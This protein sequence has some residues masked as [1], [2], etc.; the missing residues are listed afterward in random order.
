MLTKIGDQNVYD[1][2][3]M[4]VSRQ[5]G[6]NDQIYLAFTDVDNEETHLF[7]VKLTKVND[8]IQLIQKAAANQKIE[9]ATEMPNVAGN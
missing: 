7:P 6:D 5:E 9:I 1:N 2:L 4:G 3:K 8:Y